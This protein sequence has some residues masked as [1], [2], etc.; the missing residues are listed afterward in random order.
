MVH[1]R[2]DPEDLPERAPVPRAG[3]VVD[4]AAE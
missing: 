2:L 3:E 1:L 4:N